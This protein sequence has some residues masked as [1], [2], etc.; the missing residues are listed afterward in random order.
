MWFSICIF[1]FSVFLF[2][3]FFFLFFL[4]IRLPPRSTRTYTLFPYTTLFRS[5]RLRA[6]LRIEYRLR[7]RRRLLDA[8]SARDARRA[9][10]QRLPSRGF[11]DPLLF[12]P[13]KPARSRLRHPYPRRQSRLGAR[14]GIRTG[15]CH[16]VRLARASSRSRKGL[17]PGLFA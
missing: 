6:A 10:Q 7:V 2:Y 8:G 4:M 11:L 13:G 12:G 5:A 15:P 14:A 16:V 3:F 17:R 9:R 1:L